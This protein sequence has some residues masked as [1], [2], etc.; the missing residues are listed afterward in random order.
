MV[1]EG[2]QM[3]LRVG[4]S[5]IGRLDW[6]FVTSSQGHLLDLC[7]KRRSRRRWCGLGISGCQ[8]LE[9]SSLLVYF[10]IY[11]WD[12]WDVFSSSGGR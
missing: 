4:L 8:I 1:I 3:V 7:T 12:N 5:L 6:H 10:V 2:I 11:R 9:P